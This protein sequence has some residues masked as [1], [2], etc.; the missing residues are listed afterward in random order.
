MIVVTDRDLLGTGLTV[1]AAL[2]LMAPQPG[3]LVVHVHQELGLAHVPQEL[4]LAHVHQELGPAVPQ[5][6]PRGVDQPPA[7]T[8]QTPAAAGIT[9]PVIATDH[10]SDA[11]KRLHAETELGGDSLRHIHLDSEVQSE[12]VPTIR[13]INAATPASRTHRDSDYSFD[14]L[15]RRASDLGLMLIADA[16]YATLYGPRVGSPR[17]CTSAWEVSEMLDRVAPLPVPAVD[18][19]RP[20]TRWRDGYCLADDHWGLQ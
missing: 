5:I 18:M 9:S 14:T 12:A 17:H 20:A 1:E 4:G 7:A 6:S 19:A 10:A 13:P 3:E 2:A 8:Q 11:P 16:T 15:R